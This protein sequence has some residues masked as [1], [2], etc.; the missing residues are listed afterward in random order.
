MTRRRIALGLGAAA[1]GLLGA[2]LAPAAVALADSLDVDPVSYSVDPVSANTVDPFAS[3]SPVDPETVTGLYNF[4]TAPPGCERNPS[5]ISGIQH[6]GRQHEPRDLLCLRI[7]RTVS[8]S[9]CLGDRRRPRFQQPGTLRRLWCSKVARRHPPVTGPLPDGSVI[10]TTWSFGHAFENVYSAIPGATPAQDVVTDNLKTPFGTI[11]LSHFINGL[12]FD[13]AHV[14]PALP[15]YI[16]GVG[17]PVVTAINGL[18][19]LT[20]AEQGTQQ[21]NY[22]P[23]DG[24]GGTFGGVETTTED[25]FGFHTEAILVTSSSDQ[26][27]R[28]SERCTTRSISIT[29]PTFTPLLPRPTAPTRSPIS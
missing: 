8:R 23:T 3:F 1:G 16:T 21:F 12:G 2:A 9:E 6:F 22:T 11:D 17:D 4:Y 29:C 10:S 7:H 25:G 19:P 13:A 24:P 28:R 15:S 27:V 5:G 18:P 20:I 14:T 26:R